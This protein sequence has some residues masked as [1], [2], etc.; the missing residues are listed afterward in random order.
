M[1]K[2]IVHGGKPLHGEVT[3]SGAKNAA[4]A[5]IPAAL[6][7]DGVCRIENIPQISDVTLILDIL[8]DLG[9]KVNTV[10]L[11]AVEIDC[12]HIHSTRTPYELARKIR[13]SY[14]LI[15]ALLGRFGKAEVTMPGGCNFGVRPIDQHIKGFTAM[16]AEVEVDGGFIHARAKS[17]H[18]KGTQIYLDV[19][20]VGA[21]M[22]IMLAAVLAE[23]T[24]FIENAAKEPHIVD[25][26][27][28]LNSMGANVMGAGTDL[29]KIHGVP[30]L[31]GG[32]YS[33]IPDQIEAGTYMAAVAAAGGEVLIK[34]IIPKHMDCITAKLVEMG[35]SV[36]EKDD[37][38][39]VS[40]TGPLRRANIKTLPYPGFPTDMQPQITS[41]L[42]LAEGTSVVTE[43][44]WD[45]RYRYVDEL[46][47]M[48]AHIQ[49]DGKVAIVEG[50]SHYTG[51]PIQA[52]DLR[53][54]AAMVIVALA[55]YGTTE[56]SHVE[57]I[58]RGYEDIV[59]KLRS[60]GA[61]ITSVDEPEDS[62][63][64]QVG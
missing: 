51:A 10:N 57:Y 2:Y 27:N 32:S 28:F 34:N 30:R 64:S 9:A 24:T 23:G 58:E 55:A 18:L 43:S 5:I 6:L 29:I 26:A 22:N 50:I 1:T 39:L 48:G 37:T 49:V 53:A 13:A 12:S 14:Y 42:A 41:V 31:R 19:V 59:G 3:I 63:A 35:V 21:T 44:V 40:R 20:S 52:C 8:Q 47:R 25:L 4:V 17:G 46:K 16:G 45:N 33:I 38:L 15:G 56:I 36:I 60:L 62:R 54:G 61:D 7:V 11:H